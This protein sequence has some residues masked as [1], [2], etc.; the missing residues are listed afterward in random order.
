[1]VLGIAALWAGPWSGGVV[2]QPTNGVVGEAQRV[3]DIGA[4]ETAELLSLFESAARAGDLDR[5]EFLADVLGERWLSGG[6]VAR[7]VSA[8]ELL[9]GSSRALGGNV[10]GV[11]ASVASAALSGTGSK[12]AIAEVLGMLDRWGEE[13]GE[14]A[15]VAALSS[16]TGRGDLDAEGW[17]RW[18]SGVGSGLSTGEMMRLVARWH[19]AR[20]RAA[21]RESDA[22]GERLTDV[23]RRLYVQSD[24]DGRGVLL[25]ELMG[26][27]RVSL[28]LLGYDLAEREAVS[29]RAVS[30]SVIDRALSGLGDSSAR[31]RAAAAGVVFTS[32]A[33]G[34]S[35][36]VLSALEDEADATAASAMLRVLVRRPIEGALEEIV[37]RAGGA[38]SV[39][40]DDG[41]AIVDAAIEAALAYERAFGL[42]GGDEA[43]GARVRVLSVL[44]DRGE[45]EL[46][47]PGVRLL[48]ELGERDAVLGLLGAGS[49][50]VAQAAAGALRDDAGAV[51]AVVAAADDRAGLFDA[52][53][54]ALMRHRPTA[55]GYAAARGL[56]APSAGDRERRLRSFAGVLPAEELLV[57]SASEADLAERERLLSAGV[58]AALIAD[59]EAWDTLDAEDAGGAAPADAVSAMGVVRSLI[60]TRVALG[61]AGGVA[62]LVERMPAAVRSEVFVAGTYVGALVRLNRLDEAA[63]ADD[64]LGGEAASW[65]LEG[66]RASVTMP[67]ARGIVERVQAEFGGAMSAR[68]AALLAE[69]VS[70]LPAALPAEG[71]LTPQDDADADADGPPES[72]ADTG[73]G[74]A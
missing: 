66:L 67:H 56:A 45:G 29:G 17:R 33:E 42:P 73:A 35:G 65:W 54:E 41:A 13:V 20:G 50:P 30:E 7:V 40:G 3:D 15:F 22:L 62:R 21:L 26:D 12:A 28:R 64:V 5:T 69:I 32:R 53:V 27:A 74:G 19:A 37:S 70:G 24:P 51:D 4:T 43:S 68:E 58:T 63:Q 18:W 46:T 9:L 49:L 57:A 31:V 72:G 55:S 2:A 25:V 14:A 47:P 59:L 10:G 48:S 6:D 16:M 52:A 44:S 8:S 60:E 71:V 23:Y 1:M 11:A 34:V 39:A 36:R 38:G 61:D